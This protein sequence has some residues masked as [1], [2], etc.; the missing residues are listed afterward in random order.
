MRLE[1]KTPIPARAEMI[2]MPGDV[3]AVGVI[4]AK[5]TYT[6]SPDGAVQLDREAPFPVFDADEEHEYGILPHDRAPRQDAAFEVIFMGCANA[7]GGEPTGQMT[8]SLAVGQ[9]RRALL[10]SG[11]RRWSGGPEDASISPPAQFTTMPLTL[12]RAFGGS[13]EV[14]IDVDSPVTLSDERN[15]AGRG[16]DVLPLMEQLSDY[17]RAPEGF[18]HT[19]YVRLLPN[20]EEPEHRISRWEDCPDG[21]A[22]WSTVPVPSPVHAE[23]SV[24]PPVLKKDDEPAEPSGENQASPLSF[25]PGLLHRA[26]STWIIG[27]PEAAAPVVLSG[28]TAQGEERFQLPRIRV[29]ADYLVGRDQ[30]TLDLAPQLLMILGEER[31]FYLVF[32]AVFGLS[33]KSPGA[34]CFRLRVEEGDWLVP[35]DDSGERQA[36]EVAGEPEVS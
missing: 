29:R 16:F 5:A 3:M 32:R 14:H 23:R 27:V 30:G 13:A 24:V 4:T 33:L 17:L 34:P 31:R 25:K 9:H 26:A 35:G 28:L 10:I 18:P 7:P 36:P 1:N 11:D 2:R 6:F 20:M 8:V 19:G 22:C 21:P 15:S 12:E